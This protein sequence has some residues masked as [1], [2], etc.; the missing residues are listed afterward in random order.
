MHS[1]L[2]NCPSLPAGALALARAGRLQASAQIFE[3]FS[4]L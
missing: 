2:I 4:G 3:K 1:D